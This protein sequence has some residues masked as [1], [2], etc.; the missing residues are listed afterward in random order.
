MPLENTLQDFLHCYKRC[1]NNKL[2]S[3]L[4]RKNMWMKKW[5][6]YFKVMDRELRKK[7]LGKANK[8]D[9]LLEQ[10]NNM[11]KEYDAIKAYATRSKKVDAVNMCALE[12]CRDKLYAYIDDVI[13][14]N[15]TY[16]SRLRTQNVEEHTIKVFERRISNLK[17]LK[18]MPDKEL[19]QKLVIM[20]YS[21]NNFDVSMGNV[22]V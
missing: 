16:L 14:H 10:S 22:R 7:E 5:N 1:E 17:R 8:Y 19:K 18:H 3:I 12:Q 11:D 2:K 9:D 6:T 21:P 20:S 15:V 13:A 4:E